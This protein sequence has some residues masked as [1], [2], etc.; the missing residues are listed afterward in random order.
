M[1]RFLIIH[2]DI[3]RQQVDAIVNAANNALLRGG[4][5]DAAIHK[6]A[7]LKL[8]KEYSG[9]NGCKME[10]FVENNYNHYRETR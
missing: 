3:I 7:G 2:N 4:D 9:L 6:S 1:D 8:L 5:V 10:A